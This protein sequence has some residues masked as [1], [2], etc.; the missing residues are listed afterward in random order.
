M[1]NVTI[2]SSNLNG[3]VLGDLSREWFSRPPDER[4]EGT[5]SM[6][7]RQNIERAAFDFWKASAAK[8]VNTRGILFDGTPER[9]LVIRGKGDSV[10]HPTFWGMTQVC[11]RAEVPAKYLRESLAENPALAAQCLNYGLQRREDDRVGMLLTQ[12]PSG[13]LMTAC[14]GPDYGRIWNYQIL[15]AVN[16]HLGPEWTVPGIFGKAVGAITKENTSLFLSSQDMFIGLSDETNKIEIPNRRN[17]K[18]GLLSRGILIGNSEVGAAK[19]LIKFFMFDYACFNRNFWGV[20]DVIEVSIRHSSGAPAR[21]L[22]EAMPSI[23][24]FLNAGTVTVQKQ[25][26]AA[27]STKIDDPLKFL[28]KHFTRSASQAIIDVHMEEEQHPIE[29]LWDANVGATAYAR[30]LP[31]QDDRLKIETTAGAFMPKVKA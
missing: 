19:L 6:N 25:L 11:Q 17:G 7:A 23:R 21:W 15:Q 14:T 4:I 20:E 26:E 9:G 24:K 8:V 29:N 28:N 22:G 5:D 27:R 16:K 13:W 31:Y 12:K 1:A 10:V 30:R 3:G 18:P 2:K